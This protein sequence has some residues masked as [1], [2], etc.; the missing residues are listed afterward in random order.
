MINAVILVFLSI[1]DFGVADEISDIVLDEAFEEN[2]GLVIDEGADSL[3]ST[4]SD[5]S[6]NNWLGFKRVL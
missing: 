1:S 3:E 6:S 5:E 4:S 2:S